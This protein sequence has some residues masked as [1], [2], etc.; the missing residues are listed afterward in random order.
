MYL[1]GSEQCPWMHLHDVGTEA[2]LV[3]QIQQPFFFFLFFKDKKQPQN[4]AQK[5][6]HEKCNRQCY[7]NINHMFAVDKSLHFCFKHFIK[8]PF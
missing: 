1:Q 5:K 2:V 7:L 3:W 6:K 8:V 4:Q